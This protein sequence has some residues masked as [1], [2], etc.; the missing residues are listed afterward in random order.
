MTGAVDRFM[1]FLLVGIAPN[2]PN[3]YPPKGVG[4]PHGSALAVCDVPVQRRDDADNKYGV[5][6]SAHHLRA[7]QFSRDLR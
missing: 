7:F 5:P 3:A 1:A 4:H 6:D 2:S